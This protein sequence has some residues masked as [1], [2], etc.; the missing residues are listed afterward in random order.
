MP[1]K[2]DQNEKSVE[3][4]TIFDRKSF[5]IA[6]MVR[7]RNGATEMIIDRTYSWLKRLFTEFTVDWNDYWPNLQLTEMIINRIYG[8]LKLLSTKKIGHLVY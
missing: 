3:K 1:T 4:W 2:V 5:W 6:D 8:W 7:N